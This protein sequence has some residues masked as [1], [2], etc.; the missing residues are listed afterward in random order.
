MKLEEIAFVRTGV[1]RARKKA[2]ADSPEIEY[3]VLNLKC[4]SNSGLFELDNAEIDYYSDNFKSDCVT[5]LGDILI[6][7][8]A[9]YTAAMIKQESEC[10]YLVP[11]HFAII[12]AKEGKA[13]PEYLLWFLKYEDTYQK[14]LQNCSGTS[15]YGTISSGFLGSLNIEPLPPERQKIIGEMQLL[16]EKEQLLLSRLAAEKEIYNREIIKN[17]YNSFKRG[18]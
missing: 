8:S 13:L 7:L 15:I 2:V 18:N 10:G 6:R 11:S 16:S 5:Q 3:R 4:L 17:I 14:I 1:V 12:R 9:P